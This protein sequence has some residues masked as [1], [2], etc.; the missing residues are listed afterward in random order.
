MRIL[1]ADTSTA[2]GSIALLDGD[3]ILLEWVLVASQTHN[4]RLLRSVEDALR[5]VGWD[6]GDVNAFAVTVGPGSFTGLR[7]GLTTIKTLAWASGKP[8]IGIPSLDVL[9]AALA[10][11]SLPICPLIDAHKQ[12]VYGCLYH[13]DSAGDVRP[14]GSYRAMP[15][16]AVV[17]L[18]RERTLFCGDGWLLYARVLQDLLGPLAVGAAGPFHLI[19]A[20]VLGA[21]ARKRFEAG[22]AHDPLTTVP[23]YVRPSEAELKNPHLKPSLFLS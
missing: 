15:A 20:G 18:V 4:R 23:L 11:S 21:L 16:A 6:L 19:R 9:A 14:V 3:R 5:A 17:D 1:A 10:H 8:F 13:P 7:I 2:S 12:E 22:E